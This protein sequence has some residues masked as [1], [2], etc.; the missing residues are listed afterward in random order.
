MMPY[1]SLSVD[2]CGWQ[3]WHSAVAVARSLV[4]W[5]VSS[6]NLSFGDL[7]IYFFPWCLSHQ[8]YNHALFKFL[9]I[10]P[11]HLLQPMNQW[12]TIHLA[13]SPAE[14]V[15]A[16]LAVNKGL[17][18]PVKGEKAVLRS[19][20]E[21]TTSSEKNPWELE[22]SVFSASLGPSHTSQSEVTGSHSLP[23]SAFL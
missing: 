12:T 8:L 6:Y 22:G 20:A 11:V 15:T 19:E 10:Q 4:E 13:I 16:G 7:L 5:W 21:R 9:I 18:F 14:K 23:I 17:I 1:L 3:I 2:L